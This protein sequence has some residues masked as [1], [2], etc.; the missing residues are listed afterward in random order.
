MRFFISSLLRFFYV[1]PTI[2]II[3]M[4]RYDKAL[5]MDTQEYELN[6]YY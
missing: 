3:N 5:V 1:D 4:M 2:I 6:Y